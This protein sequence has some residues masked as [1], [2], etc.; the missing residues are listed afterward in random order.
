MPESVSW[1]SSR[2]GLSASLP[3]WSRKQDSPTT[4]WD[5]SEGGRPL[6]ASENRRGADSRE[7]G[8][9]TLAW[10]TIV[11]AGHRQG[12][13]GRWDPSAARRDQPT[14]GLPAHDPIPA[15]LCWAPL[16]RA[17]RVGTLIA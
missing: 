15:P 7:L 6:L 12:E 2:R 4:I 11:P 3:D 5:Y 13:Q 1:S 17:L 10:L 16:S 9:C 14:A 8:Q